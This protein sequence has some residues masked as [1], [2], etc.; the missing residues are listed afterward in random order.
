MKGFL[1]FLYDGKD[2]FGIQNGKDFLN[3]FRGMAAKGESKSLRKTLTDSVDVY[4]SKE[5]YHILKKAIEEIIK[6]LEEMETDEFND[7][8]NASLYADYD[9]EK[10]KIRLPYASK[11]K[12]IPDY[13]TLFIVSSL[14][15]Q[16][17]ELGEK[18]EN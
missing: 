17:T 1:E 12:K 11:N 15:L 2:E 13:M 18:S 6:F 14:A 9:P 4:T 5:H 16:W 8:K 7:L 3:G 10:R